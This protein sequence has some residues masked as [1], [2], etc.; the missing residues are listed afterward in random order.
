M[1]SNEYNHILGLQLGVSNK[2]MFPSG[3]FDALHPNTV[4]TVLYYNL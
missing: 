4:S 3:V 2:D 1:E